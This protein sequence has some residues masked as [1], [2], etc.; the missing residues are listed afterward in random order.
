MCGIVGYSGFKNDAVKIL[1]GGL[2]RLEYRGYD[3]CG[4]AL[5]SKTGKIYLDRVK[6]RVDA[7]W[8]VVSNKAY[9]DI[10]CG[11]AH[12]RWATHG[13]P[14]EE[15]AHPHTDC[16]QEIVVVHNGIIEN[17]LELKEDLSSHSFRSQTDTEI[18]PHLIEENIKKHIRKGVG[19]RAE[20]LQPVFFRAFIETLAVLKG[21]FAISVIWSKTPGVILSARRFSPLVVGVGDG[22]FFISSD[23]VGFLEHTKKVYFMED[24]EIFFTD[25]KNIAFFDINGKKK[26]K[27]IQNISWD[28]K[29]AE[30]AGYKHFMIK[31]IFEQDIAFESTVRGRVLPVDSDIFEKE[32]GM[33]ADDIK[34]FSYV[35]FVGCGTAYHACLVGRYLFEDLSIKAEADLASEF[36]YRMKVLDKNALVFVI[37]QSGETADTIDAM[38]MA[39]KNGNKI[40][41]VVNTLG[42]TVSREADYVLYTHCGPEIA[43][44]S[45]KAFISQLAT[46]YITALHFSYIR[47]KLF[48]TKAR[49]FATQLIE[50]P[51]VIKETFK[52]EDFIKGIVS[53]LSSKKDYLYIAR[54][55]NYPVALEGALKLKEISYLHAEGYTGGEMKHGPIAIIDEGM[56][57]VAIAPSTRDFELIRSNIEEVMARGARV[58]AVCDSESAR[59]IRVSWKIVVPKVSEYF[60]P[61]VCVIPLQ[62]FAYYTALNLGLDIDKP[63]N[64][65]KSVTVK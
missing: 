12:T 10:S 1:I 29:M 36:S 30:K 15:N 59:N 46:L 44:A 17:Y 28:V 49:E 31:E 58:I 53:E 57:V 35:H 38:R 5:L 54:G 4:I 24:D 14:S 7:L 43:V 56:P 64:L 41:A 63:R 25:G 6:G 33:K 34:R 19:V 37:T 60:S 22:E 50:M 27:E 45:T 51:R 13:V 47:H 11:I 26:N 8:E 9:K 42:S 18:I 61:V 23:V 65:A 40:F 32:T 48:I 2:R 55:I 16:T 3:S 52:T 20:M 21:S 39:K 62:I